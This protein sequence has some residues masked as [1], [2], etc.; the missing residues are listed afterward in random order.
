MR[1]HLLISYTNY[2]T[3]WT[4]LFPSAK[5]FGKLPKCSET[6]LYATR[7]TTIKNIMYMYAYI[8]FGAH[9]T[10]DF[11]FATQIRWKFRLN[12]I[13]SDRNKYLYM[14]RQR[15]RG[16]PWKKK[17]S[18]DFVSIEERAKRICPR[19]WIAMEKPLVKWAPG[20]LSVVDL[21]YITWWR[22]SS[23]L[24]SSKSYVTATSVVFRCSWG[25]QKEY[26][27]HY[28]GAVIPGSCRW[29]CLAF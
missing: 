9:F 22:Y 12:V 27:G 28:N 1:C 29:D 7:G 4:L 21:S 17:W 11:L 18:D 6:P 26:K 10:K 16:V 19:I 20:Q 5:T 24:S 8:S 3:G 13:R 25:L 15:N 2:T 23:T 14:P